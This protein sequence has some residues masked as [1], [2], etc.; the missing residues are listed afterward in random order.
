MR[1]NGKIEKSE[2]LKKM[3]ESENEKILDSEKFTGVLETPTLAKLIRLVDPYALVDVLLSLSYFDEKKNSEISDEK[4][5]SMRQA[6]SILYVAARFF[7][8]F[9]GENEDHVDDSTI[10]MVFIEK[11]VE[12][13]AREKIVG[14][15]EIIQ[16]S[17]NI[18]EIDE[19]YEND[20]KRDMNSKISVDLERQKEREDCVSRKEKL[21]LGLG[22]YSFSYSFSYSYSYS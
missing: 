18:E 10:L 5:F 16:L 2:K 4:V 3:S 22:L 9:S 8:E 1:K 12:I 21:T 17:R 11:C 13:L 6:L 14:N 7:R 20:Q 19:L 15:F